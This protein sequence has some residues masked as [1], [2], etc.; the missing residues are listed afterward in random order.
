M[1]RQT[2]REV[3]ARADDVGAP[4]G[5]VRLLGRHDLDRGRVEFGPQALDECVCSGRLGAH[6]QD[7]GRE[8]WEELQEQACG[9]ISASAS[10]DSH[11]E[12]LQSSRAW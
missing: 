3:H 8:G 7:R 1:G 6:D 4:N 2:G 9:A 11:D 5:L 12:A 10:V